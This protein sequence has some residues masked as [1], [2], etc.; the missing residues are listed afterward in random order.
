MLLGLR[1]P[2]YFTAWRM[3][4]QGHLPESGGWAEQSA[5]W[6][7]AIEIIEPVMRALEI[8]RP[9]ARSEEPQ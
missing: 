7:E 8:E 2:H 3:F 4:V 1:M 9:R 5:H 6:V